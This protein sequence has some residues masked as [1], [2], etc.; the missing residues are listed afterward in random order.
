MGE[1][2]NGISDSMVQCIERLKGAEEMPAGVGAQTGPSL[3]GSQPGTQASMSATTWSQN[4]TTPAGPYG[5]TYS[6]V[7]VLP[8]AASVTTQPVLR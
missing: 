4:P 7:G 2:L 8:T 6:E 5:G 3:A 1:V